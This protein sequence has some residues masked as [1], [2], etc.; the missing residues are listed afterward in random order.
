MMKKPVIVATQMLHT[1]IKNP[2]PTRAEVT[3]IANAIYSYTDALMLSGETASG[4]YPLE[5]VKTMA[6]IAEQAEKDRNAMGE[7]EVPMNENCSHR[8]FLAHAAIDA[9]RRIGVAGIITDSLTGETVRHLAAFRGP[10]PVLAICYKE[11]TQRWLNLSYGVIPIHQ[12]EQAS[13]EYMFIAALR[14]LRQKGYITLDDKIAYLSGSFGL[15]NP[16]GTTLLEIN[17]VSQ[18]FD[19]SYEFHLPQ[20]EQ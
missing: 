4:K 18:V 19:K 5:A 14:M 11:K 8:E 20:K 16:T 10:N 17:Q 3:D 7:W 1:M 12:K 2:R 6:A 13:A 15:G 9:T